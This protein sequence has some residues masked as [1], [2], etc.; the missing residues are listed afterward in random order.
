MVEQHDSERETQKIVSNMCNN[1]V[2]QLCNK[3][4][5]NGRS[6]FLEVSFRAMVMV[7]IFLNLN[8]NLP[9][10]WVVQVVL[11]LRVLH[12]ME[13]THLSQCLLSILV[14]HPF[15]SCFEASKASCNG[16]YV[17]ID[18]EDCESNMEAI[19]EGCIPKTT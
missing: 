10:S 11:L 1:S 4:T 19:D 17:N 9:L 14:T 13:I 8:L 15:R 5:K 18:N 3:A 12:M 16:D 7:F 2:F 6:K